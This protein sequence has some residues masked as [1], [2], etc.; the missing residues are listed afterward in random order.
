MKRTTAKALTKYGYTNCLRAF[1]W[2]ASHGEGASSIALTMP[3]DYGRNIST[4]NQANAAINAG[5][6]ISGDSVDRAYALM[7]DAY[8]FDSRPGRAERLREVEAAIEIEAIRKRMA[9][10]E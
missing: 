6:D 8:M 5:R 7:K 10:S 4:T 1:I 9:A 3:N 2:N